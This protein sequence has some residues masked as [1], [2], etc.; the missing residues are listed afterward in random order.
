MSTE[1]SGYLNGLPQTGWIREDH[2]AASLEVHPKTLRRW[3]SRFQKPVA[4]QVAGVVLIF[5]DE[6]YSGL[7]DL[8]AEEKPTNGKEKKRPRT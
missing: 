1:T 4:K 5:L 6:F 7:P 8:E 3:L 2:L